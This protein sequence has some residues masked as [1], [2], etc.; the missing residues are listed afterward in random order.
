MKLIKKIAAI[1]FAFMMVFSLSTNVRA[2]DTSGDSKTT[3]GTITIE[4]SN[5]RQTY[6]LYRILGLESYNKTDK[7]YSYK[8]STNWSNF[9]TD[10]DGAKDYLQETN[11]YVT[12]KV[13][14]NDTTKASFIK[15]ALKYADSKHIEADYTLINDTDSTKNLTQDL[16]LGYYL[17]SSTTGTLCNLTTT[18]P[19]QIIADKNS[20]PTVKKEIVLENHTRSEKNSANIGDT[21][22]FHTVITVGKGPKNYVLHDKMD[23]GLKFQG[24]IMINANKAPHPTPS[25]TTPSYTLATDPGD[26]CAFHLVFNQEYLDKIDNTYTIDVLYSA[27]V[28]AEAPIKTG[29]VN[30]TWLT[31]G[32][33]NY[34][35][36]HSKTNTFTFNMPVLKYTGDINNP[37]KLSGAKF[38]LYSDDKCEN[39]I[40][41]IKDGTEENYRKFINDEDDNS[42]KITEITTTDSG[43]FTISGLKEGIYYLK[44]IEAPKGYNKLTQSLTVVIDEDGNISVNGGTASN[45]VEVQNNK[46]SLLPSTGG[47]GTTLIYLIGGALV[48]GSGFVLANKKRAK[49]K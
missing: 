33:S 18:N 24:T 37:K 6:K 28:T 47:M 26:G 32:D 38:T 42:N 11:G 9:I 8:L 17:V 35:T 31:Y 20:V 25:G 34:S 22:G 4:N 30:D 2:D 48:L 21:V 27:K 7:A 40:E 39:A 43:E 29:I 16:P 45:K 13:G 19:T 12:W 23:P 41:L 14:D 5:A 49:A 1:M 44:E 36:T 46:G 3:T 15:L 10:D